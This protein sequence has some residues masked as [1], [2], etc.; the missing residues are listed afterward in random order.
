MRVSDFV[1][2]DNLVAEDF[3]FNFRYSSELIE[4]KL[5][6][7]LDT[8]I[9]E[10]TQDCNLRCSY[11]IFGGD[12]K[13]ERPHNLLTM[14]PD[15]AMRAI[16]YF[17][18]HS[19]DRKPF[20]AVSFYGGEPLMNF[21]VIQTAVERCKDESRI[22][23]SVSTNGLSLGKYADYIRD[24]KVH[25][26]L[27][28]DGPEHIHNKNRVSKNGKPTFARIMSGLEKLGQEYCE[29]F[30]SFSATI[31]ESEDFWISYS[32]FRDNYPNQTTRLEFVKTDDR[33]DG[34]KRRL[35][36]EKESFERLVKE[37]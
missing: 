30:L 35:F 1:T 15:I 27:S 28:L 22:I 23:V 26:A 6:S 10:P 3:S 25:V 17:L 33:V 31:N 12:Y 16:E 19:R 29:E 36:I 34:Q 14:N 4:Q 8:L 20:R 37:Y 24:N 9:L 5:K 32:F 11:C 2:E 13:G 21:P 18:Q 7:E